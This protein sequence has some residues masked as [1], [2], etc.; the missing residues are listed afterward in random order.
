MSFTISKSDFETKKRE[1]TTYR[2]KCPGTYTLIENISFKSHIND[3]AVISIESSNVVLDLNGKVLRQSSHN[4]NDKIDGIVV[5]TGH[6]NITILGSYGSI[7]NFSRRGIYVQGG[8]DHVTIG[9]DTLLTVTG[10]GYGTVIA[11]FDGTQGVSQCGVQLGD[12]EFFAFPSFKLEDFHGP[13]NHL[14]VRNLVSSKNCFGL[15]LGEG[16][17][18]EFNNCDISNNYENRLIWPIFTTLNSFFKA[19]AVVSYGLVYFSNPSLTPPPNVGINNII[20]KDCKFNNNIA[21][22]TLVTQGTAYVD[23]FIMAVNFKGLKII[24][25]QFNSNETKLGNSGL[26]NQ[27]RGLVLGNGLSTV[28]EDSEFLN[29]L[30]GNY[31]SGFNQSGLI[32][33]NSGVTPSIFQSKS[34]TLRNCVSAGNV[35]A[36]IV[37]S[38]T[39]PFSPVLVNS[40]S[41]VGFQIRYP[42]SLTMID[43]VAE[44]NYVTLPAGTNSPTF[45]SLADGI[46]IYSDRQFPCNFTNNIEI[47]GAKLSKNRVLYDPASPSAVNLTAGSSGIRLYDDLNENI[48]IRD[49]VITNN[50]P[51]INEE[52]FPINSLSYISAGIDLFNV[53]EAGVLKTGPSFISITNNE[54]QSNGRYGIFTN[55]DF[56][57]IQDNRISYHDIAGVWL[58]IGAPIEEGGEPQASAFSSVIDNTF[59]L[60]NLAVVDAAVFVDQTSSSLIA[61]NKAFSYLGTASAYIPNNPPPVSTGTID[62]FPP[63]SAFEWANID[64]ENTRELPLYPPQF[65]QSLE[66]SNLLRAKEFKRES[67]SMETKWKQNNLIRKNLFLRV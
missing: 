45:S 64:I 57:K 2:I 65:C 52:P 54:I 32:A 44:N 62:S 41:S 29:N 47:R 12:M 34:V 60:N 3:I 39:T 51:G 16:H 4:K 27:T 19:N 9:D 1:H 59:I 22:A 25:C 33:T 17:K 28:I 11:L 37:N 14:K 23:A 63:R 49:C 8:N 24:N 10:C 15:A 67:D 7:Q 40:I 35:A 18:Y 13:L 50:L 58:E 42:S 21:D 20:F 36:P 26:F 56:N 43:C 66:Q 61:G 46:M 53:T 30:G 48:I 31:V 38:L 6:H 5:Q 55:L